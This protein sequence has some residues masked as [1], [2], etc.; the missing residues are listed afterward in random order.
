[1]TC[2]SQGQA[3]LLPTL[4]SLFTLYQPVGASLSLSALLRRGESP[5]HLLGELGYEMT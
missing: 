3:L 4:G 1:M 2:T 5:A